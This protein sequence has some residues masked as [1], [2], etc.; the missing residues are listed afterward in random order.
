MALEVG[1]RPIHTRG[2]YKVEVYLCEVADFW[3]SGWAV[4]FHASGGYVEERV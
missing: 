2:R 3:G 4:Y 1:Y